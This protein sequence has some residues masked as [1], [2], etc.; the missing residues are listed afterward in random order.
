MPLTPS[1]PTLRGALRVL[2]TASVAV[3]VLAPTA[4]FAVVPTAP[5]RLP[6]VIEGFATYQ[7]QTTCS[8]TAKPGTVKLKNLLL[9]TYPGT[10]SLGITRACSSGGTSEHKEGRAFDWGVRYANTSERAKA[11]AFLTWLL[12]TDSAG[13]KAANARRLGVMY[14]IWN[15]KIWGAYAANQG[16]RTY[17]GTN[18]HT[19]HIHISL[20]WPGARGTTSFWTGKVNSTSTTATT[21]TAD[22]A[23]NIHP[24][25]TTTVSSIVPAPRPSATL[26]SGTPLDDD[27]I[28][29]PPT[30]AGIGSHYALVKGQRYRV[31]V[32]G[33]WR[34]NKTS[35]SIA[36]AECSRTST[37][38]WRSTRYLKNV[39]G[40][41]LGL[42]LDGHDLALRSY[43][44]EECA[45]V[46]HT[47]TTT[48]TATRT[49]RVPLKLWE[50]TTST[51]YADNSGSVRVRIIRDVARSTLPVSLDVRDQRGTTT[52]GSVVAGHTYTI[53]A[54]G[55]FSPRSGVT[56]DAVCV[57]TAGGQ[58][59]DRSWRLKV[60]GQSMNGEC[61]PDHGYTWAFTAQHSGPV[62]VLLEDD[63]Q[64]G[65]NSGRLA[66]TLTEDSA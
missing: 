50:P 20:S 44:G 17:T 52:P 34:W 66:V 14:V 41:Q 2:A 21:G 12:K 57:D 28:V 63:D 15:R 6:S 58:E 24:P 26:P 22:S 27:T 9:A 47:F 33:T 13:H 19:D 55:T 31:E 54:T 61:S 43:Y 23:G 8:P 37:S 16:W 48:F 51:G 35:G 30:R 42:Y 29:V 49:G 32:R 5:V 10:R 65:D 3:A 39:S 11:S 38:D 59:Q 40:D 64:Y 45:S 1:R 62:V 60:D 25:T 7:K 4:A 53:T 36:D 46:T 56:A 18:P